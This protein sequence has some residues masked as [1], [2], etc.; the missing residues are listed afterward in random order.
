MQLFFRQIRKKDR[1]KIVYFFPKLCYTIFAS[2]GDGL[3]PGIWETR[4]RFPQKQEKTLQAFSWEKA[5]RGRILRK[6]AACLL[7]LYGISVYILKGVII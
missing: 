3:Y 5:I 6:A 2:A 4:M 7:C 1:K